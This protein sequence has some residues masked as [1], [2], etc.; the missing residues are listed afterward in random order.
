MIPA[1]A[2]TEKIRRLA[3][4]RSYSGTLAWCCRMKKAVPAVA[5]VAV[6]P[7]VKA[8]LFGVAARLI[9][10]T[11]VAMNRIDRTPPGLSTGALVSL[12]WLGTKTYRC[13]SLEKAR[14]K[15]WYHPGEHAELGAHYAV[16][17]DGVVRVC[18]TGATLA[19]IFPE[20]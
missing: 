7:R 18:V 15:A 14:Q 10:S 12:T 11:S 9:A 17:S 5:A 3:T 6:S 13:R 19:E 4:C 16:S 20:S 2:A 1:P 8:P